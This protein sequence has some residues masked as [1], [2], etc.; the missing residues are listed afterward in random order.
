V[1]EFQQ[2]KKFGFGKLSLVVNNPYIKEFADSGKWI[3]N[4]Y[5]VED[6]FA[7]DDLVASCPSEAACIKQLTQAIQ[8]DGRKKSKVIN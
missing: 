7:D 4:Y 6:V 1:G 5:V 8:V 3:G 2:D